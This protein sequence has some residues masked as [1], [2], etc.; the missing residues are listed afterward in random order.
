MYVMNI[1]SHSIYQKRCIEA[2]QHL[3]SKEMELQD[4]KSSFASNAS[5][6]PTFTTDELHHEISVCSL[7]PC[8]LC[9]FLLKIF[10]LNHL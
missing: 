8:L 3:N 9:L 4:M 7:N 5:H 2:G 10:F 1:V 6:A